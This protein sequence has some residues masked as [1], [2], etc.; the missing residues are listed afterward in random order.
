LP[1]ELN[2]QRFARG[3][4][5]GLEMMHDFRLHRV[6][7]SVIF[8]GA[9]WS[10]I[11]C[12]QSATYGPHLWDKPLDPVVFE[13]R[14]NEQLD[15]AQK[16]IAEILTVKGP[17]AIENTLTPYDDAVKTLDTAG[18][19]SGLMQIA[20]PEASVRD[21]AQALVQK[22]SAATTALSL[23]QAIF[24]ALSDLDVS[25]AD[26]ATQYYIKRTLLEF[27]LAGVDKDEATRARIQSLN[28]EITK[29]VTQFQ[30]NIQDSRLSVVVKNQG[31]LDGL[32]QDYI[33]LHKPAADGSITLTSD[34]P[35]VTPVLKFA[36][37]AELRRRVYLAYNNRAYPQNMSVLADLLTRREELAKVVGYQNWSDMAA[38]DKMVLNSQTISHFIDEI[39]AASRPVAE[40]EY[41][42]LLTLAR[43]ERPSLVNISTADTQYYS[44]QF[45][46]A[47]FNFDSQATRQYFPYDQVQQGIMD[48]AS[49]L[50]S[51]TFRPAQDA[52]TWDPSVSS[53]DVFDGKQQLGRIYLDMHPRPGKDQWFSSDPVLDG[54]R[55]K[56]L[57]EVA[58]ICNFP[59]GKPGDPGLMEYVDVT[60]F[61]HE[62]GHLM[63]WIFQGQQKW[64]GYGGS[65]ETDFGEAPS[66]MLEEW[67][68]DPK[69]LA[70][71]AHD[72]H[73]GQPIPAEL[74]RRANLADAFGRGLQTRWQLVY[75][76]VSF[77]LHNS[78]VDAAKLEGEIA[79]N[80]KRF[81]P[82]Q[83]VEG[84][85]ALA[86]FTHLG[87]YSSIYYTYLW[88]HVIAEDF[89]S[90]F[91]HDNLL[92]PEVARR[93]RTTVL[94]KTGSMPASDLVKNFLGR[95][96]AIDGFVRWMNR[97]FEK[98]PS[99]AKNSG[100]R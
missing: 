34:S 90:K 24:H 59:G 68:H 38:A 89:L 99:D 43:K 3:V 4:R 8:L 54:K 16:S 40:R 33:N 56:Q 44:E 88:D 78:T 9:G 15:L 63:H 28:D 70:I 91:D 76:N 61:F 67:M 46:R 7:V 42:M 20:S 72:P 14:V 2:S 97:E 53:F 23:N 50:F 47:D 19:Q 22:V 80:I 18:A 73:T 5:G 52:V 57:P 96:Q 35:D 10:Q 77:D 45:G 79:D 30:R 66:M 6:I 49:R 82:Y 27:R 29:L 87:G 84:S 17:R 75:T 100:N 74:V 55:G 37:D 65:L 92:A 36:K 62:F 60:T 21:R 93:Y 41:Q 1:L 83:L 51:V 11:A 13:K 94:E 58:L 81:L 98:L 31:E 69:V 39:D 26:P 86:S 25:M 95:P 48:V 71:F 32:P 64:A 85:H 12:G